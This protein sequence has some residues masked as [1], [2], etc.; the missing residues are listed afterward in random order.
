MMNGQTNEWT[1]IVQEKNKIIDE[2]KNII[3]LKDQRIR[4]LQERVENSTGLS[5]I[6]TQAS[7]N[8][9]G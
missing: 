1:L 7:M 9:T 6:N 4:E 8:E 2:L 5:N 3:Q